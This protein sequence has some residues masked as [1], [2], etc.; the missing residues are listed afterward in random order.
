MKSYYICF[1]PFI[2]IAVCALP[3]KPL[4]MPT[5]LFLP[6]KY[7]ELCY[8]PVV[9]TLAPLLRQLVNSAHLAFLISASP[10][11]PRSSPRS[12]VWPELGK[13][14]R[15]ALDTLVIPL[16]AL[17]GLVLRQKCWKDNMKEI[18]SQNTGPPTFSLK[19]GPW[20]EKSQEPHPSPVHIDFCKFP[21]LTSF[22]LFLCLHSQ[23]SIS[24]LKVR[25]FSFVIKVYPPSCHILIGPR[26]GSVQ[27]TKWSFK[28]EAEA[29]YATVYSL[30]QRIKAPF[31]ILPWCPGDFLPWQS[32]S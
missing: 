12:P 24:V 29:V 7:T 13:E 25:L 17:S 16:G 28:L 8:H 20:R 22:V 10:P 14:A 31:L 19:E 18:C 1:F 4:L 9:F 2:V 32:H 15:L 30:P 11:R 26:E 27:K 23:A 21:S 5:P 6:H 3:G